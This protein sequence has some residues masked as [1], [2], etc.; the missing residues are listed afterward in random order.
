MRRSAGGPDLQH[1]ISGNDTIR[2]IKDPGR[3]VSLN[4]HVRTEPLVKVQTLLR[5]VCVFCSF[6]FM[7]LDPAAASVLSVQVIRC[8]PE[9]HTQTSG[10]C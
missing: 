3:C 8:S 2:M 6:Y 1:R 4:R 5:F 10:S 9:V 7:G